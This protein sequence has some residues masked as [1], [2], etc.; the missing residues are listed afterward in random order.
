MK[1]FF[2]LLICFSFVGRGQG[3][4]QSPQIISDQNS[5]N[6]NLEKTE[7]INLFHLTKIQ[8][9]GKVQSSIK[10]SYTD[11]YSD[12][13]ILN[14]NYEHPTGILNK[15]YKNDYKNIHIFADLSQTTPLNHT[16]PDLTQ[17]TE[18]EINIQVDILNEGKKPTREI[19]EL[20]TYYD[21]FPITIYNPEDKN[22]II[23]FGNHIPLQLEALDKENNWKQIYG[24][25]R[26]TCGNGIKYIILK[27]KQIAIVFVPRLKGNFRTTFRYRLKNIVSNEF[28]GNI[29]E[30]YFKN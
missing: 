19:P 5:T 22:I 29:D 10:L 18:E 30:T 3:K 9:I 17:I 25:R 7:D 20:T 16:L 28:E 6:Q 1:F 8:Y 4:I 13:P 27:S 21:G 12:N 23:G 14:N 2:I 26:Y 24:F 15:Q 11:F